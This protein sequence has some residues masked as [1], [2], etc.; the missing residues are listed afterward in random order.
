MRRS[1]QPRPKRDYRYSVRV[2]SPTTVPCGFLPT[3]F[4]GMLDNTKT[5]LGRS[6]LRTWLLM[7]SLSLDVIHA[8]HDAVECFTRP[9]NIDIANVMH[10]QLKGIKNVP[11]VLSALRAGKA[12]LTDWQ[13]LVKVRVI[14]EWLKSF[15]RRHTG[16]SSL[17]TPQCF[18]IS[19][20]SSVWVEMSIS[21]RR[22]VLGR[23]DASM[24]LSTNPSNS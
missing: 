15:T 17:S 16:K 24:F 1:T 13:G 20:G 8:R 6:L 18:E 14:P 3:R 10:G 7:P 22:Y 21:S 9:E 11:R 19:S 12:V 5:T 23:P 4:L 2:P